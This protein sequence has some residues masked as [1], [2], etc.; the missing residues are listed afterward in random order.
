MKSLSKLLLAAFLVAGF[1][2][3][4]VNEKA[5]MDKISGLDDRITALEEQMRTANQNISGLQ[6]I[7]SALQKNVYVTSVTETADGYT[8]AFSDQTVAQL[9][10]GKNGKDGE[11]GKDGKDGQDGA[12]PTI[13]VRQDT[14]QIWYW[15]LNG[16]WLLND[17]GEKMRVTGADGKDGKD[18]ADGKDGVDGKDG[19]DGADAIAPQLKIDTEDNYWYISTDGGKS[20]EKLEKAKG[21]DG[22]SWFKDVTWDDDY[23][24]LTLADETVLQLRRGEMQVL[25]IAA[26]PDYSDGSV[27]AGNGLFT[28][29]F[30]VDPEGSAE[31][32]LDL[33]NDCFKLKAVYT[34]TK[35]SAG[36]IITLPI[37]KKEV[38]EDGILTIT[39]TGEEL[40]PEFASNKIGVN[41]SLFISDESFAVNSGYFPLWHKNEYRGHEY[42][43]LG[44]ESGNMW[45]DTN[46]GAVS[47]EDAGSYYAWGETK[48]KDYFYWDNYLWYDTAT[49]SITK[50]N[51][52]DNA[53][54]YAD[55]NYEDD[56]ARVIWGGEWRTPTQEDWK[57]L[58]DPQ[59]FDWSFVKRG[60]VW[61]TLLTSKIPGHESQSI[62]LPACGWK[63][64]DYVETTIS[65]HDFDENY[66]IGPYW[67]SELYDEERANIL[68]CAKEGPSLNW[69][70]KRYLGFVT[71]RPVLGKYEAKNVTGISLSP[72]ALTLTVG[73]T[74]SLIAKLEPQ[75]AAN[76][77]VKWVSANPGVATVSDDGAVTAVSLGTAVIT[78]KSVDGGYTASCE[79]TVKDE[80]EIVPQAV[81]LGLP[82]GVKWASFNLG[83]TSPEDFGD[84]YAWGEPEPYYL[85]GHALDDPCKDWKPGKEGGYDWDSYKWIKGN[86]YDYV[87]TKYNHDDNAFTFKDYDYEDDVAR[88]NWGG[89]WRTPGKADMEELLGYCVWALE[90]LNGV[91]GFR[92]KSI[93]NG[94]SIFL[95][96]GGRRM[97]TQTKHIGHYG[98]YMTACLASLSIK[99][100]VD[101]VFNDDTM[102]GGAGTGYSVESR[103]IGTLVRPVLGEEKV[104]PVTGVSLDK[105]EITML[106]GQTYK[107]TA[108]VV[109]E[110]A[111]YKYYLL[112]S[113]DDNGVVEVYNES[114]IALKPGKAVVTVKTKDGGFQAS[115]VVTVLGESDIP[116]EA[117]DLGLPS[118]VKWA[119]V[120]LGASSP[121]EFGDYY[122]WGE[123]EPYYQPGHS[124]DDP[125]KFWREGKVNGYTY[126]SYRW[127][128]SGWT[129]YNISSEYGI[130]DNKTSFRDYDYEDDAARAKWA[131][132]WRMPSKAD[133]DELNE[134]CTWTWTGL[135]GVSG[136]RVSGPSGESIFI[137]A[138]GM[139]AKSSIIHSGEG[140][141]YSSDL[142]V[143]LE[144]QNP[145]SA[146]EMWF[147]QTQHTTDYWI[148]ARYCGCS[149]R[150]VLG[151]PAAPPEPDYVDMGL[152]VKW[153]KYNVGAKSETDFG[154]YY[155]WGETEPY[156]QDGYAYNPNALW[157]PGKES[158]YYWPSYRWCNGDYDS[159]T[160]YTDNLATLAADDD[161]ATAVM[162]D[163]WRMPTLSEWQE[164]MDPAKCYWDCTSMKGIPGYTVT[165]LSTGN[166]IFLPSAGYRN[167]QLISNP[168][169]DGIIGYYW[170][171]SL[172]GYPWDA[173]SLFFVDE[174]D[175]GGIY[176]HENN[177]CY[178]YTVR[179]VHK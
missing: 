84:Y 141:Y 40:A 9:T 145:T 163:D 116:H 178:G 118:G 11:D 6:T 14:D 81:D 13:G 144:H 158:G 161:A 90:E 151:E 88:A 150:P 48:P 109:P 35:A 136:Y 31:S 169:D 1:A 127:Y 95:P 2:A 171:S 67:T 51:F 101:Y 52:M 179:A 63:V 69:W 73:M 85:P 108:T 70:A 137:P 64:Y 123:T 168:E 143:S 82:S 112:W 99:C 167:E 114:V 107:F 50:Y 148:A 120:N 126:S 10:N 113:Y 26:I 44:L 47:S 92:L 71:V 56:P 57:E 142:A 132:E 147:D 131:G 7:T 122:A 139:R 32:L 96:L 102:F 119:S 75:N 4:C 170:S 121:E 49:S 22:D 16:D 117:V 104:I 115:C 68:L 37:L 173:H 176:I 74:K 166:Y 72:T 45:A 94:N 106:P 33:E 162:G 79:V 62:F 156:Y 175:G 19:K 86:E 98:Q 177:R 36:D 124:Q 3:S 174:K 91:V 30:N 103:Y 133:W 38:S 41:V 18:G 153:A 149:V 97:Y 46:L 59:K 159:I 61:G 165:S 111:T 5:I 100:Y 129:R 15:T 58:F 155:A 43:D 55:Y 93:I 78:V 138:A 12:S 152:S 65:D 140:N 146:Y 66:P 20:W 157:K 17:K 25:S 34:L 42:V 54:S 29:R 135:N 164:L 28:I 128:S 89:E 83:A 8:I 105:S 53:W 134:K 80:S 154:D 130:V 60:E 87:Y 24:F 76:P 21:E 77:R 160:K 110:D 27:K 23:V 125:C 172:A 39:T